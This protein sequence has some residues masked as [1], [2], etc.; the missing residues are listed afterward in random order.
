[1]PLPDS[2]ERRRTCEELFNVGIGEAAGARIGV[3][4]GFGRAAQRGGTLALD[5]REE[6][7]RRQSDKQNEREEDLRRQKKSVGRD[8]LCRL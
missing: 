1:M 7:K 6:A 2:G 3:G 4:V 5:V 8:E